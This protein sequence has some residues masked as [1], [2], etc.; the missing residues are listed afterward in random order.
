MPARLVAASL[1]R[2]LPN[3]Y[4]TTAKPLSSHK[5]SSCAPV[6]FSLCSAGSHC[7]LFVPPILRKH[8]ILNF[9]VDLYLIQPPPDA[10]HKPVKPA[11]IIIA[12]ASSRATSQ[13]DADSGKQVILLAEDFRWL[14]CRL[15]AIQGFLCLPVDF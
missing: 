9:H 3:R 8:P 1:V 5:L 6:S 14:F 7:C 10:K 15:F 12:G 4:W 11:H 13:S 2:L